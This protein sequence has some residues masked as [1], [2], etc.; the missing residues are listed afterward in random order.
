MDWLP[1]ISTW[2]SHEVRRGGRQIQGYTWYL[3][4]LIPKPNIEHCS[5]PIQFKINSHT[6]L[7]AN[8]Y[9]LS[10]FYLISC[11]QIKHT[12]LELQKFQDLLKEKKNKQINSQLELTPVKIPVNCFMNTDRLMQNLREE[13]KTQNNQHNI[14]EQSC[15]TDTNQL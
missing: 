7:W 9:R 6:N 13:A 11:H 1:L 8:P 5:A 10:S 12:G 15:R 14:E 2:G 3:K 4:P